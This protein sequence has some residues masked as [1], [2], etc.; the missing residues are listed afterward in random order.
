MVSDVELKRE[1][2]L[3][4]SWGFLYPYCLVIEAGNNEDYFPFD[5]H[6]R[7]WQWCT[8]HYKL[9]GE[10]WNSSLVRTVYDKLAH[11]RYL[12]MYFTHEEAMLHFLLVFGEGKVLQNG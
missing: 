5:Q 10:L 3:E 8:D 12:I 9:K 2:F 11:R 1:D 4:F 6:N 7:Y